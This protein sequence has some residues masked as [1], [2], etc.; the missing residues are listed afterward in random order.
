MQETWQKISSVNTQQFIN[1]S[2]AI[3]QKGI[4]HIL[5]AKTI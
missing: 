3:M 1:I 4:E 2:S 5:F